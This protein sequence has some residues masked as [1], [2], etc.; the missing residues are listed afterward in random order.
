M[1]S[2]LPDGIGTPTPLKALKTETLPN[3]ITTPWLAVAKTLA[4][5][6]T[7]APPGSRLGAVDI[8]LETFIIG[9]SRVNFYL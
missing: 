8:K 6:F 5:L 3:P 1:V 7:V 4:K 2:I 9:Y